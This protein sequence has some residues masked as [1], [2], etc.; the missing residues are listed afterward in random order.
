MSKVSRAR[1]ICI[2][3]PDGVG[4]TTHTRALVRHLTTQGIRARYQW[5]RFHHVLSLPLLCLFRISGITKTTYTPD[6]G[7]KG[8]IDVSDHAV[9][10]RFLELVTIGD[11]ALA[12]VIRI[13][14]P[15]ALGITVV[16]DR[17]VIDSLID[18]MIAT[19]D[20]TLSNSWVGV[21][22]YSLMPKNSVTVIIVDQPST[23]RRRRGDISIDVALEERV[24]LYSSIGD[25]LR[26][27]VI[28]ANGL[29]ADDVKSRV[30]SEI[31]AV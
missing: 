29:T 26:V 25:E 20:R 19:K 11:M 3:G 14:I 5:L 24:E 23:L 28:D 6:G 30:I 4:K 7:R 17:Y 16:C 21:M 2:S 12:S 18:L 9:L 13:R 1:L 15:I 22:L 8:V 27:P 31:G 10:A